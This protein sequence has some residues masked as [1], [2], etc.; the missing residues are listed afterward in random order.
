MSIGD[1]SLPAVVLVHGSPGSVDNWLDL[2]TKTD[3]LQHAHLIAM[4]RPGFGESEPGQHEASLA[5]QAKA[6]HKALIPHL[7]GEAAIWLGHSFG[8]PVI[9]RMAMDYPDSVGGLIFSAASVDPELEIVHW[10]Q[11]AADAGIVSWLLPPAVRTT[12]REILPLKAELEAMLP[13]WPNL[14][15]IPTVI[16]HG[17]A[18]KLVPIGN[19]DFIQAAH[20]CVHAAPP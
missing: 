9:A 8:G 12:N 18:D 2:A 7:N 1:P 5:K 14:A 4:D 15:H 3:V 20:P 17:D 19:A 11:H 6:I 10:Y 16:V 13:H